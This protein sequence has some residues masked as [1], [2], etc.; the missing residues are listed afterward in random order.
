M[1]GRRTQSQVEGV[2]EDMVAKT[3]AVFRREKVTGGDGDVDADRAQEPDAVDVTENV[4]GGADGAGSDAAV[5][6]TSGPADGDTTTA[7]SSAA[8]K[9]KDHAL[10]T[11][12]ALAPSVIKAFA[13]SE[14]FNILEP[15]SV[16]AVE[17]ARMITQPRLYSIQAPWYA[18][19]RSRARVQRGERGVRR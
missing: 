13:L 11:R 10:P 12:R 8:G 16:P 18:R 4:E 7:V 14:L 1:K 19:G 5:A 6:P 9:E 3:F 15:W 2:V 17:F